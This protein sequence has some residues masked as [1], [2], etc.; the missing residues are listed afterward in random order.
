[1]N[2]M[3]FIAT[4]AGLPLLGLRVYPKTLTVFTF[5]R[6]A[7]EQPTHQRVITVRSLGMVCPQPPFGFL[8]SLFSRLIYFHNRSFNLG[9]DSTC[10]SDVEK[11]ST[12][13]GS[14]TK[15][16]HWCFVVTTCLKVEHG[17]QL[18]CTS[19]LTCICS[20]EYICNSHDHDP[21]TLAAVHENLYCRL[22]HP[23]VQLQGGFLADN[24]VLPT[25]S[26]R[27][28][29]PARTSCLPPLLSSFWSGR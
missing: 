5:L 25:V 14:R 3:P 1:M 22:P 29:E 17:P 19:P 24:I 16:A 23:W 26:L 10:C 21:I 9:C 20:K 28:C 13:I 4:A 27:V 18:C 6:A 8:G 12:M 11:T 15:N 7:L 2:T